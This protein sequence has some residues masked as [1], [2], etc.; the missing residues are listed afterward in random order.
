MTSASR[1]PRFH[2]DSSE[3]ALLAA[4]C[5]GDRDAYREAMRRHGGAM[6]AAARSIAPRHAEDAVQEAWLSACTAIK[7]FE[8]RSGLRTWLVRI[9]IN[10]AYNHLRRQQ[11]EVSLEGLE[12]RHDPLAGAFTADGAWLAPFQHWTDDSPDAL[13]QAHVLQEC[14]DHHLADLPEGQ[15]MALTLKDIEG[16][17]P[18][19]I[20]NTLAITPSNFRVLLHRARMRVFTMVSHYEETGEC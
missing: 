2:A 3:T 13:L 15:R 12:Q 9:T 17:S 14:L 6:L 7:R 16:L 20:C 11:R 18:Q 10:Q 5:A 1:T 8:G 19:E 4:L